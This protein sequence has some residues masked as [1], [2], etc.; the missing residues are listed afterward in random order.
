MH[1][2]DTDTL[3]HYDDTD[4][5]NG[6]VSL[7]TSQ[8]SIDQCEYVTTDKTRLAEMLITATLSS[9]VDNCNTKFNFLCN[10]SALGEI[11]RVW[12]LILLFNAASALLLMR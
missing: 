10:S 9:N 4:L 6:K 2:C 12:D 7:A 11:Y 5:H 8:L 3:Y 1:W